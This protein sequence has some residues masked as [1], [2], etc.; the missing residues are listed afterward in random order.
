ME[1][2][3]IKS[4]QIVKATLKVIDGHYSETVVFEGTVRDVGDYSFT[5]NGGAWINNRKGY[6]YELIKDVLPEPGWYMWKPAGNKEWTD[7]VF[8][9][10]DGEVKG[11]SDSTYG[12]TWDSY[13]GTK[14]KFETKK[15]DV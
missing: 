9:T 14:E 13:F 7:C 11:R 12:Y 6:T 15:I 5:M 3:D 8:V 10:E 2:K 1:F 4:G